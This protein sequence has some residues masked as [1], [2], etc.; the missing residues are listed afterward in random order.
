MRLL[1]V[2]LLLFLVAGPA[3]GE[4]DVRADVAR[5]IEDLRSDDFT[6][7]EAAREQLQAKGL[8]AADLLE[9]AQDDEDAEVR[10]T[11]R[12]ILARAPKRV[13]PKAEQV[14]PGDFRSLGTISL[15]AEGRP[16]A[17]VLESL[18]RPVWAQLR[19][20][21]RFAKAPVDV[22]LE[23]VPFFAALDRVLAPHDLI[24]PRAFDTLGAI[25]IEARLADVA[26]APWAAS[27]PT[28]ITVTE[29]SASRALGTNATR[30]YA[31]TLELAWAPSVQVSQV[32]TPKL[33]VARDPDGKP[34]QATPAMNRIV[35]YGVS[36]SR[37]SHTFTLHVMPAAED[38][39]PAL[40][41]LELLLT[42]TLRFDPIRVDFDATET[43]PQSKDGVTLHGIEAAEG[44]RGQYVVDFSAKL[45]DDVAD[46]SL[47]AHVIEPDGRLSTLSVY[48]GRSRA[49][50]GTVRIRARAWRGNRGAPQRIRIAWHRRE[51]R[52]TLRYRLTDVP[53]R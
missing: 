42:L 46:R 25:P 52:G 51:D 1:L 38:V 33:E 41:V 26:P 19:V 48:G 40:G 23:D 9:A 34:Y 27:G 22:T 49:A 17:E 39:T 28:R 50:D 37:R 13:T 32:Q 29:V 11:V 36:T 6:T 31:L 8:Q 15:V 44:G 14:P 35:N 30:K 47:T 7:R 45:P 16:L 18:G 53:L 20:P 21:E 12:A 4:E 10:R 5:W 43:L 2:V 3:R 24:A